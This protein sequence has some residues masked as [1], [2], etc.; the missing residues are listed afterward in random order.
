MTYNNLARS[1]IGVDL[2]DK[3]V[4]DLLWGATCFPFYDARMIEQLEDLE[5]TRKKLELNNGEAFVDYCL[6]LADAEMEAGM[7]I[8]HMKSF[9]GCWRW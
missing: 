5:I 8:I 2:T 1:I 7:E 4:N 9:N 6:A 3:Q